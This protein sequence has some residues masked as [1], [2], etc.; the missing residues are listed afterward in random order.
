LAADPLFP[1]D[2]LEAPTRG[3]GR[4]RSS[5]RVSVAGRVLAAD[6]SAFVLADAFARVTVQGSKLPALAPGE[7]VIARGLWHA[8]GRAVIRASVLTRIPAPV[9]RGDGEFARLVLDGN[10][11][12]LRARARALAAVREY[13]AASGFVEVE[14]PF[15][16]PRPGV[17]RNVE[18]IRGGPGWLVTSPELEMKRLI[19]GG[20]PRQFQLA[21]VG[22]RDESGALHEPE[23]TLLEWYRAFSGPERVMRD[24]EGVIDAVAR[25]VS[26]KPILTSPDGRRIAVRPPFER[27][28]VRDAFKKSARVA[29]A[30]DLAANDENRY[31]ELLV[32]RVEPALARLDRPVFLFD[33]PLSEAALARPARSAGYAERFELYV[34]GVELSNGY[35]E[36]TDPVEQRRRFVI[37]RERRRREHRTVYPINERFLAALEEGVPPSSGNALG[38]DRLVLLATGARTIQEVLAF[39]RERL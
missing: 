10:G 34:A 21:R 25:A 35:G 17:D 36:L 22:R 19:A 28:S 6:A 9:P 39:P 16:V 23:F 4:A 13:F 2:L 31:F 3:A 7:L 38:L 33:Y 30:S 14:T 5:G 11:P 8:R 20:V 27:V 12:R 24:T 15:A 37:E 32:E 1:S 26:K 29:D 18:A